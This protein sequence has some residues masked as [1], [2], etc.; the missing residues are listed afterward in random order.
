MHF[1]R[2]GSLAN[3]RIAGIHGQ[4]KMALLFNFDFFFLA[5]EKRLGTLAVELGD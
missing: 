1:N 3:R 5:D 4:E 2:N